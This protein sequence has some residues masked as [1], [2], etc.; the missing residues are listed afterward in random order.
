MSSRGLVIFALCFAPLFP[1]VPA[2]AHAQTVKINIASSGIGPTQ[3]VPYIAYDAGIFARNGLDAAVIRTRADVAVMSMLAG[4]APILDVAA[5]LIIRSNLKGTDAVYIGAGAVALNYWLMSSKTVK[6]AQDLKGKLIGLA[7]LTGSTMVATRYALVKLGLNPDKD[8]QMIQ[9]GGT[10]ERLA[11]LRTGRIQATLLSPPTNLAAQKEGFIL[12][13]EVSGL[14][15]Q[16]NG[17]VTTRKFIRE[18]PEVVKKYVKS[19][20]ETVHLLKT[21]R[22][23][24]IKVLGK[25][26]KVD[27]DTL[28]KS[29]DISTKEAVTPRKQYPSLDALKATLEQVAADDP[30]ARGMAPES[31]IDASF[32]AELDKSGYI[33]SL[34][35]RN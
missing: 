16:D 18:R 8:V 29:Y 2:P 3:I 31:L 6:S 34:Y 1:V 7:S 17:P 20:V 14:P 10:P 12:L 15:F 27:R 4:E 5:P 35:K 33:D 11:A 28:E 23:A 9:I 32:I 24:W 13:A 30:K 26:I 25:Y 22:E 21:N 19:Q